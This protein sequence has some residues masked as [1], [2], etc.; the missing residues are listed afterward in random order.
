M[1]VFAPPPVN[2]FMVRMHRQ[3]QSQSDL[4]VSPGS[5]T[6]GT[7][8]KQVKAS[9]AGFIDALEG[10]AMGLYQEAFAGIVRF[11]NR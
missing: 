2:Q 1:I 6:E 4:S 9:V 8:E 11:I 3:G 7:P 10:F 5:S